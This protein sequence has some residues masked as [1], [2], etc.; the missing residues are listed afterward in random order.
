MR[1]MS[2]FRGSNIGGWGFASDLHSVPVT[3]SSICDH[4]KEV[5]RPRDQ[6]NGTGNRGLYILLGDQFP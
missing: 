3:L 2:F 5:R 1:R 6:G 4:G